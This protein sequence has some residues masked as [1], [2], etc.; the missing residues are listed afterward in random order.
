VDFVNPFE[1]GKA[2]QFAAVFAVILVLSKTAQLR[3]GPAG[4]RIA[5]FV[6]G[7]ADVDAA[8]LS[9]VGISGSAA[10]TEPAAAAEAVMLAAA[11][12]TLLKAAIVTTG[13]APALRK[14]VL[15]GFGLIALGGLA[16]VFL[17]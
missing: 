13:G 7:L 17:L 11:A 16:A 1:L 10:E 4:T 2:L 14:A 6:L 5:A 9:V 12:N 15:P 8:V 3:F